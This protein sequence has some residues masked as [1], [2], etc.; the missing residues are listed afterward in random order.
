MY[1]KFIELFLFLLILS[2]CS[3]NSY[4]KNIYIDFIIENNS[5]YNFSRF[6]FLPE[7]K[8][9]IL[10]FFNPESYIEEN[11]EILNQNINFNSYIEQ[12]NNLQKKLKA[13]KLIT[14][15][16]P[17]FYLRFNKDNFIRFVNFIEG[18]EL[19]I[20]SD[21]TLENAHF[22]FLKGKHKFYGEKVYEFI[23]LNEPYQ[24]GNYH[25]ISQNKHFRFET[26]LLNLIYQLR[27]KTSTLLKENQIEYLYR[28]LETNMSKKDF[29]YFLQ[30]ISEYEFIALELPLN[31]VKNPLDNENAL[32]LNIA[33]SIQIYQDLLNQ[34]HKYKNNQFLITLEILN[35]SGVNRMANKVKAIINSQ[36]YQV[37]TVDNFPAILEETF[38]ISNNGN[39]LELN[40]V[41]KL[42]YV[43]EK[44]V[45]F[46]R[47]IKDVGF[48]YIIGKDFNIKKLLKH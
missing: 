17:D 9:L 44:N 3:N 22:L 6:L 36:Y 19:F 33:K 43:D 32:F 31:I 20:T 35:A 29:K 34:I 26:I 23:S 8:I 28:F 27:F 38:L 45:F 48:S 40:Q 37:L 21:L 47:R 11:P 14:K 1:K 13:F 42:L 2:H 46:I 30:S 16:D 12:K 5:Y 15:N 7:E 25:I 24:K 41:K 10:I 39:L 4:D 18:L